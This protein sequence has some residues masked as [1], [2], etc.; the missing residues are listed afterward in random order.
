ML[1]KAI[2]SV[3]S[4]RSAATLRWDFHFLRIRFLARA[5]GVRDRISAQIA[6]SPRPLY[7][8]LGSGPRGLASPHWINVDGYPDVNVQHLVDLARPLPIADN[9]LDG[10]FSEHVQEHFSLEDGIGLLKECHRVLVPGGWLRLVM[11][12]AERI[13]KT[14]LENPA[15]LMQHRPVPSMRP[16]EAVN[17]YFRQRYEHQCL[18]DFDLASHAFSE[19]GFTDI[20]RADFGTGACPRD[21]ILDDPK[22]AWES[23]YVDAR[24]PAGPE[25]HQSSVTQ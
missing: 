22:Y 6:S 20:T 16:M 9:M 8:N 24:K 11:P 3:V 14:Y 2:L 17:A 23:L 18:Y 13:V 10:I 12:D 25:R 19:A 15:E 4:H 1:R 21:L 7:L 5:R